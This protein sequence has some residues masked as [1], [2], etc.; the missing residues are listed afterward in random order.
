MKINIAIVLEME[1]IEEGVSQIVEEKVKTN[2]NKMVSIDPTKKQ[3][4]EEVNKPIYLSLLEKKEKVEVEKDPRSKIDA[5][6]CK[7]DEKVP[8]CYINY[9]IDDSKMFESIMGNKNKVYFI[10]DNKKHYNKGNT[11]FI[12]WLYKAGKTNQIEFSFTMED[13]LRVSGLNDLERI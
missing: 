13:Q 10:F 8:L 3:L 1:T 6:V 4:Q 12:T 2:E 11:K 5:W 7:N 9:E